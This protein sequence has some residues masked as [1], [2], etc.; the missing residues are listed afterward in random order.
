MKRKWFAAK[1]LCQRR[2]VQAPFAVDQSLFQNGHLLLDRFDSSSSFSFLVGFACVDLTL[3][4]DFWGMLPF[5]GMC[6][7]KRPCAGRPV[8]V[9]DARTTS[10]TLTDFGG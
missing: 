10:A 3:N 1:Q 2:A 9:A 5:G 6:P 4:F 7:S 8:A